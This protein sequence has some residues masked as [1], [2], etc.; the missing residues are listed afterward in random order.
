MTYKFVM[1]F[2]GE[3]DL[4]ST[5]PATK[6]FAKKTQIGAIENDPGKPTSV[7]VFEISKRV[8]KDD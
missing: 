1:S 3:C 4:Y 8:S 6:F 2:D 7:G 5:N